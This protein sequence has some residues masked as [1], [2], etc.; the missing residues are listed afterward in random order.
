MKAFLPSTK[1]KPEE[2]ADVD[3]TPIMN[4][5]VVL[6]PLLLSMAQFTKISLLEYLPPLESPE[7]PA[8]VE[9]AGG[10]DGGGA[11][12]QKINLLVNL[13]NTSED[14]SANG[15]QISMYGKTNEGPHFYVIPLQPD[16]SYNWEVLTDSL[17]SIKLNEVGAS[18]GIDSTQDPDGAWVSV[19]K[20]QYV[21]ARDISITADGTTVFQDIVSAMD[22]CRFK[23]IELPDGLEEKKELFPNTLLKQFQ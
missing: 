6:I 5:V 11:K 13:T 7:A 3:V 21:D 4:L 12:E 10:G 9:P 15:I 22:A 18:T 23:I 14:A 1:V 20:F 17:Y 8:A 2:D 19:D 16:Q